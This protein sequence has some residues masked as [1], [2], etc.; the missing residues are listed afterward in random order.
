VIPYVLEEEHY[1][2]TYAC[3][4]LTAVWRGATLAMTFYPGRSEW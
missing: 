1:A 3:P 2:S 4:G